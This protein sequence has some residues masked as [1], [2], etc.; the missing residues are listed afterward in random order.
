MVK[1]DVVAQAIEIVA[2]EH[3]SHPVKNYLSGLATDGKPRIG[4]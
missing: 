3:T 4:D 2:R 1:P